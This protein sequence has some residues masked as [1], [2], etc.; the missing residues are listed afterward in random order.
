VKPHHVIEPQDISLSCHRKTHTL[1][2]EARFFVKYREDNILQF[3][4]ISTVMISVGIVECDVP[5]EC[6]YYTS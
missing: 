2:T 4:F 3:D 1:E 5:E 6:V